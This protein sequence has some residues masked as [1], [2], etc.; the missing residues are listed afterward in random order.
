MATFDIASK[1]YAHRGLW[2]PDGAAENS[3]PAF[4]AAAA[5]DVG[6]ELDVR[7]TSDNEVVVFHDAFLER[8][9][10]VGKRVKD[11]TLD[12]LKAHRFPDKTSIPTLAEVLALFKPG[13]PVLIELK[14][15]APG[16]GQKLVNAV[17][18]V[19]HGVKID[20]AAMSFDEL[21]VEG[22]REALP[23]GMVGLLIEPKE[24]IGKDGIAAKA[25]KAKEL[26][27]QY[28]GP[29]Y[30]SLPAARAASA[31]PLVTWTIKRPVQLKIAQDHAAAPIFEGP[32]FGGMKPPLAK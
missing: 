17:A 21:A 12:K 11:F 8:M 27:C 13:Q 31:L 6:V 24:E 3:L 9:F 15:D 28:L 32:L 26:G 2:S 5:A 1:V 7:L 18:G 23:D 25:R 29:H 16:S 14:V 20:V 19:L 30:T 4:Q 22:L 10:G